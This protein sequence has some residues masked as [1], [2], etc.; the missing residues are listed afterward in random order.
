MA[1]VNAVHVIEKPMV[2]RRVFESWRLPQQPGESQGD[3]IVRVMKKLVMRRARV[4]DA[5]DALSTVMEDEGI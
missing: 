1:D 2:W 4:L 3:W 5:R